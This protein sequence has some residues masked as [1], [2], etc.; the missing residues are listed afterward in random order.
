MDQDANERA[1]GRS[2]NLNE[3]LNCARRQIEQRVELVAIQRALLARCLHFDE[4][5]LMVHGDVHVYVGPHVQFLEQF[6]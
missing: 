2:M 5:T 6:Q 4:L 1:Q 3:L